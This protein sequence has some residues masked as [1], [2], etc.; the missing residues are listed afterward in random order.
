MKWNIDS[1]YLSDLELSIQTPQGV[2]DLGTPG[3]TGDNIGD[4]YS[5]T[6]DQ[7]KTVAWPYGSPSNGVWGFGTT[8]TYDDG[9]DDYDEH[10]IDSIKVTITYKLPQP[11]LEVTSISPSSTSVAQGDTFSFSYVMK[12]TGSGSSSSSHSGMYL[13]GQSSSYLLSGGDGWDYVGSL[14]AGTSTTDSNSFDTD[15]LSVGTHT[16]WIR[17]DDDGDVAGSNEGNNWCSVN[18]TVVADSTDQVIVID[19]QYESIDISSSVFSVLASFS[20]AAY[21]SRD[22]EPRSTTNVS[23][24]DV[25]DTAA[26]VY[27][28]LERSGW[29]FL[30]SSDISPELALIDGASLKDWSYGLESGIFPNLNS[31]ALIG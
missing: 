9:N 28:D 17:A 4:S 22:D 2:V 30:N 31:A 5:S 8:D 23:R 19:N 7:S 25:S 10:R 16:L 18:F 27:E 14:S 1:N 12:N 24:N 21:T 20:Q 3:N 6:S 13:D 11:D 15:E 26:E 29:Y